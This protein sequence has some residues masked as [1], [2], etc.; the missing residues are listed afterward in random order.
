MADVASET[1]T[2]AVVAATF[3]VAG[4]V[5]G[6]TGMGL[7]TVA[8]GVLGSVLSPLAAAALLLVPSFVTNVWQLAAGPRLRPL[9]VR[10]WPMM[11]AIVVG[12][13][14]GSAVLARGD[15]RLTTAGLGAALVLYAVYTL[16][17]RQPRV[18][19]RHERWLSPAVGFA[20]GVVTGG[21]GVFV[22]P[23]VPYLQAL[24]L[25]KDDLVQALGL[26]FTLSTLALGAG[27]AAHDAVRPADLAL[28]ALAVA[29]A[30]AGMAAGQLI[31]RRISPGTFRRWFLVC[32]MLLGLDMTVRAFP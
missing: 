7:P 18:P 29:P 14:A 10:L 32:L 15:A 24:D 27:L 17:A 26:S 22:M 11:A 20:T 4:L 13:L 6:V 12:T 1:I 16:A 21:T 5:K 2:V 3:L 8:M 19:P 9:A 30:L 23:A 28:S 25:E 31:R